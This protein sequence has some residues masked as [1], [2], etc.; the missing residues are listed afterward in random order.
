VKTWTLNV[1]PLAATLASLAAV[2]VYYV[3][4]VAR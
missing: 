2:V 3:D 4:V 1:L